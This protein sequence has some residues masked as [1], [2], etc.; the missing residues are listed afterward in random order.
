MPGQ[1]SQD[2][3]AAISLP[4][5]LFQNITDRDN[6][7][8][9]FALYDTPIL[10]PINGEGNISRHAPRRPGVGSHILGAI[11]GPDLSFQNLKENITIVLRLVTEKVRF[12]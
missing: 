3:D 2:Q 4:A 8:L 5:S 1:L 6:V 7:G 9:F 10:F 12:C 11:V